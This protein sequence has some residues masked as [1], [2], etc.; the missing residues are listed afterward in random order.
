[1]NKQKKE[2]IM[3]QIN[4]VLARQGMD[5][6]QLY[7]IMGDKGYS[8]PK[9]KDFFGET[10]LTISQ[11]EFNEIYGE[12][13]NVINDRKSVME[14]TNERRDKEDAPKS[15]DEL[16]RD[17][18]KFVTNDNDLLSKI[19]QGDPIENYSSS[20]DGAS[21][22]VAA[23]ADEPPAEQVQLPSKGRFYEGIVKEKEGKVLVRPITLKEEKVFTTERLLKTG[24]AFDIVFRNCIK[25]PGIDT[26][27]ILSSDRVFLLFYLRAIS[28][29][30]NYDLR[31]KCTSCGFDNETTININDLNIKYPP[32]EL[33]EP[34]SVTLPSS[35]KVIVFK[36]SRG[37][38]EARMIKYMNMPKNANEVNNMFV[39]RIMN[40][41]IDI[42]GVPKE[43]WE[44][45]LNNLIGMDVSHIRKTLELVDFGYETNEA[46]SCSKCGTSLKLALTINENF[47]RTK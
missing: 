10:G 42:E 26:T 19:R 33:E 1:M 18:G 40:L 41:I 13:G 22:T 46:I 3:G 14:K 29:G 31:T 2:A 12:I 43:K 36:M 38:E 30:P 45:F 23:T 34:F 8:D 44:T 5:L 27:K 16:T 21:Y 28:Y 17:K 20:S 35:K 11:A 9:V 15:F 39:D 4:K 7:M 24:Q 25:T 6:M 32:K 47:F 37:S